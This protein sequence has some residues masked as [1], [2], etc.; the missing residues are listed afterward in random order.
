VLASALAPAAS[1]A[2]PIA[3][4]TAAAA[5]GVAGPA[6]WRAWNLIVNLQ[7]LPQPY[8]C[9]D[10][11]YRFHDLLLAIG[12]RPDMQILTYHCGSTRERSTRSPSVQ[13]QFQLPSA[14]SGPQARYA[15]MSAVRTTI[16]F[17]PGQPRSLTGED[18][19][20]LKQINSNLLAA[21]PVHIVAARLACR[22]PAAAGRPFALRVQALI[23]RS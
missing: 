20:L 6:E 15:D 13:L 23:P 17:G 2:T 9:D 7:D 4:A 12:A 14:L 10:L 3:A 5:P 19:E 1:A 8:S 18:C 16:S 22:A 21:L 11:W